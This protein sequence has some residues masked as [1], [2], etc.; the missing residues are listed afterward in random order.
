M[1]VLELL[2][3]TWSHP[4]FGLR[5]SPSLSSMGHLG[6][7]GAGQVYILPRGTP[8]L[9]NRRQAGA[10]WTSVEAVHGME[11]GNLI[12]PVSVRAFLKEGVISA[13]C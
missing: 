2:T 5:S 4:P 1:N 7:L 12:Q 13:C 3:H 10:F 6:T 9:I 11:W 8:K